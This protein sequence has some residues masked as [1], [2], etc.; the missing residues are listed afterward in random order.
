MNNVENNTRSNFFPNSKSAQTNKSQEALKSS[1]KRN[2]S[3]RMQELEETRS[4][5]K[6]DISNSIRDFSRIKKAVDAAPEID[7]SEK[8][9]KLKD[10]IQRGAYQVDYDAIADRILSQEF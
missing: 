1:L 6:V 7:N 3:M 9:A 2:D 5:A 4:D 8:I 10:Q